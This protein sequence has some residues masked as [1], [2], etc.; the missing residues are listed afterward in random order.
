MADVKSSLKPILRVVGLHKYFGT[1]HILKGINLSV[2]PGQVVVIMG[3]SGGGKS[4][5]LRCL[6]YL[7]E[8]TAGTIEID[9]ILIDAR[10][11]ERVRTKQIQEIRKKAALIFQDFN[12][13]P[14]MT[15]LRNIIEGAVR[16]KKLPKKLAIEKAEQLLAG[17]GLAGKRD[18]YPTR[19]SAG[20]QQKVA[21]AR[22]LCMEPKVILFDNPTSALD[23]FSVLEFAQG[24]A[25]LA[26]EG[27]AVI[28]AT[29]EPY[30]ARRVADWVYILQQGRWVEMATPEILFSHPKKAWTRNFLSQISLKEFGFGPH[31]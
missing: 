29:N 22:S 30:I 24:L 9:G 31:E 28:A 19:L 11:E 5:L 21:I 23:S 26:G 8:P 15:V 4:T 7:E 27:S 17:M 6:N 20:E 12:L 13:F 18:Q 16:V 14:H 25:G 10:E 2:R 1:K 3:P